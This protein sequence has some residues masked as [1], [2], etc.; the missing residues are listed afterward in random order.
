MQLARLLKGGLLEQSGRVLAGDEIVRVSGWVAL[1]DKSVDE[2]ARLLVR[3]HPCK[4]DYCF[5]NFNSDS[6][7]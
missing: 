7:Y 4:S 3:R 2:A 5:F 1:Q 6:Y